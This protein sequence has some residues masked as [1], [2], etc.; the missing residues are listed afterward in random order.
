MTI[1]FVGSEIT[2]M[3]FW[4]HTQNIKFEI[5]I[6]NL[7]ALNKIFSEKWQYV[8]CDPRAEAI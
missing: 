2:V 3:V 7:L 6:W 4:L 5:E 8:Q 1:H